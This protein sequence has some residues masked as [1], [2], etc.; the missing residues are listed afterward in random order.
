MSFKTNPS[1]ISMYSL[2]TLVVH[3]AYVEWK[4][5]SLSKLQILVNI[6]FLSHW[7]IL[8]ALYNRL[9]AGIIR[10]I[11]E[12]FQNA[13][14]HLSFLAGFVIISILIFAIFILSHDHFIKHFIF[15]LFNTFIMVMWFDL[16]ICSPREM[17]EIRIVIFVVVFL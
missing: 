2:Y 13:A 6:I 3:P 4:N 15:L 5:G 17:W 7:S 11:E 1:I 14:V 9:S 8:F 16:I 10:T 12:I